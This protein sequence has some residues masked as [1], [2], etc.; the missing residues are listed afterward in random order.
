MNH[1]LPWTPRFVFGTGGDVTDWTL[2]LPVRPWSPQTVTIGGTRTAASGVPAGYVVRRD[3]NL[4][5]PLRLKETELATLDAM[6]RWA[7]PG[8]R[9][10]WYP[11]AADTS[12]SYYVYLEAPP[13]GETWQARRDQEYGKVFEMELVFRLTTGGPWDL[14]FFPCVTE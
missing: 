8:E 11:D 14:D 12:V 10:R 4:V 9:V 5:V 2:A 3:Y 13:A 6:I 1:N 7:Q